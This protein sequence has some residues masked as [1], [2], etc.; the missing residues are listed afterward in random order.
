M[1]GFACVAQEVVAVLFSV[2]WAE[3]VSS[4]PFGAKLPLW[5]PKKLLE[6]QVATHTHTQRHTQTHTEAALFQSEVG[7]GWLVSTE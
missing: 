4:H 3:Q 5:C 1:L 6:Q 2:L 7:Y